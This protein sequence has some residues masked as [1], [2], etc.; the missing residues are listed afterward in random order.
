MRILYLTFYFEPDI[1]PGS[2]RNTALVNELARQLGSGSEIHVISTQPN[3]YDSFRPAA[4]TREERRNGDCR[5]LVE[6]VTVPAH[7]SDQFGQIRSFWVYYWAA[8]RLTR[9]KEYDL[10]V[11]SS[12]RLF[13]AFLGARLARQKRISLFLDIRDLFREAI[14]DVLKSP[15]IRLILTALLW[16]VERYTFGYARHINLV[17]DGFRSYFDSFPQATYS[18]F[19]NGIDD[20]FLR[21]PATPAGV[22]S[23]LKVIL[24]AGNIGE[25][26]GLHFLIPQAARLLGHQYRF[27]IIGD[28]S[29]KKKLADALH[30]QGVTNVDLRNSGPRTTLLDAYQNADYLFLHLN[31]LD[32]CKRV[33]PSKLFE[34]AATDKPIIAG[35]AGYAARFVREYVPNSILFDPGDV[36]GLMTQLSQMP[37]QTQV[38]TAF[39]AQFQRKTICRAMVQQILV[40]GESSAT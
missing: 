9:K 27:V 23:S 28:G 22:H 10:V 13:T 1:G 40:I 12:S 2:F 16:A 3:R 19:T 14:L 6:R 33:L 35:V 37:Y 7:A 17:S 30:T 21:I 8:H 34:Y 26:Q 25:G 4:D 5:V 32:A 39:R 18:Y 36:A 38:R 11:A 24:Y 31:D 20:E 29:A 15:L